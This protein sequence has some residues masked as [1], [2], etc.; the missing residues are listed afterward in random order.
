MTTEHYL[1]EWR[2][3]GLI[4]PE[5]AAGL[6]AIAR[7]DRFSVFLEL[8]AALYLGVLAIAAGLGW[9]VHDHFENAGDLLVIVSL[10][11]LFGGCLFYCFTRDA[12]SFAFDYVL[13]LG[14]LTF[15]VLVGYVEFRFQLLKANWDGWL[16]ASA[17][18]YFVLAYRFDNRFVLSLALSTLAGWFGVRLSAWHVFDAPVRDLLLIYGALVG[19][20]GV[21]LHRAGLKPHFLDAYLHVSANAILAALVSGTILWNA[22]PLWVVA[23]V[24]AVVATIALGAYFKRFAFVVYGCLYGYVGISAQIARRMANDTA[25][26]AYFIV[27]GVAVVAG[28]AMLARRRGRE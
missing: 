21:A 11:A 28:L 18:L 13:Y 25:L 6:A 8:N 3:A 19:V 16:L 7:K 27:S 2:D 22:N 10:T 9:T 12:R 24:V 14:C 5:Q 17:V 23:L 26:F 1:S 20:T 4:S 15:A